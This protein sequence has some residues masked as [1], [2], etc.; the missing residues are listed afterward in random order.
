MCCATAGASAQSFS[1]L[2]SRKGNLYDDQTFN[3]YMRYTSFT[4]PYVEDVKGLTFNIAWRRGG[5]EKGQ[6]NWHFEN[7]TIGDFIWVLV[8]FKKASTATVDKSFG[9]GFFG[10]HQ[11]Y[12]NTIVKDR[13]IIAPG[14]SLGDYIFGIQMNNTDPATPEPNGYYFHLGPA[15]KVSYVITSDMWVEGYIHND[16][17]FK[18]SQPGGSYEK[19]KGYEK[20]YFFNFGASL[21]HTSRFFTGFR[22]NKLIDRGKNGIKATRAD[23]SLGYMF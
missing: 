6:A 9:G 14:L 20:P 10:W 17:A 15:V 16:I 13:L 8:N 22:V 2:E 4:D 3:V 11:I 5:H 7:P 1:D 21:F 18:A 12:V 19:I 23:I